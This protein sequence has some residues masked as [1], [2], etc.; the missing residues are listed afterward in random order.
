MSRLT[1]AAD[2]A[3]EFD[4][5]DAETI[6]PGTVMVMGPEG[7]L[8]PSP[9]AY[10]TR[11]AGVV[12][13]AGSYKPGIVLDKQTGLGPRC[14]IALLGK[15]FCRVDA[16][17]GPIDVGDLLTT[18]ATRGHAMKASDPASAFGAVIGKALRPLEAGKGLIPLPTSQGRRSARVGI[19]RASS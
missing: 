15:V 14:T 17:Y 13:G 12:S 19:S 7:T 3:E 8:H 4:V 6:E 16:S 11:V 2:C 1:N 18:S 5:C 9:C 10:D